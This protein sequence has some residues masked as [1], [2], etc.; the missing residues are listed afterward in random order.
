MRVV[1]DTNVLY[2]GIRS[3]INRLEEK[4]RRGSRSAFLRALK[5]ADR[6]TK[7]PAREDVFP[8]EY[9][10]QALIRRLKKENDS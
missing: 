7:T 4:A 8:T 2:A 9:D 10:R 1:L 3:G 5:K 6:K